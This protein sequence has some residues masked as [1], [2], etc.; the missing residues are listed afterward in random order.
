M[1]ASAEP[2]LTVQVAQVFGLGIV[3][4]AVATIAGVLT[5]KVLNAIGE[6]R[7][8]PLIGAAGVCGL[9]GT[10]RVVESM[11]LAEDPSNHLLAH[12]AAPGVAG[13][14]GSVLVAGL[15]LGLF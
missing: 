12:T 6:E 5:A 8:N 4:F 13:L 7:I 3:G 10:A 9:P 15:F 14:L 1:A 2:V 11:G